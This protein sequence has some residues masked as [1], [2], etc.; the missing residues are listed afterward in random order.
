[1][2]HFHKIGHGKLAVLEVT[3]VAPDNVDVRPALFNT[4][5]LAAERQGGLSSRAGSSE[6]IKDGFAVPTEKFD[7][8]ARNFDRENGGM[9][10]VGR[11][12]DLPYGLGVLA[13][14][15]LGQLAYFFDGVSN[16]GHRRFSVSEL[17]W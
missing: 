1:M 10:V 2:D 12:R 5:R 11:I 4:E 6:R 16:S 7:E 3:A 9:L 8:T 14:F 17:D 13:P 15:F